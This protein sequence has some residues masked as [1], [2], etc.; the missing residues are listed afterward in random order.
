M[1]YFNNVQMENII[2]ISRSKK[3]I[4]MVRKSDPWPVAAPQHT[5]VGQAS[6]SHGPRL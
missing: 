1:Q 4:S 5:T 3:H 6:W 2:Q